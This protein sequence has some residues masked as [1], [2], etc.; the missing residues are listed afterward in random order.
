MNQDGR[1]TEQAH[2]DTAWSLPV[3]MRLPSALIVD[4]ANVFSLLRRHV[5]PG[6]RYIEV[7]CAPG[8]LLAW[9][10][11]RLKAAADGV[12]YSETGIKNCRMLFE[13]LRLDVGLFQDDFFNN[14][15]DASSYDVV[16]SFG[17]IEHFD[18]PSL[19]VAKHIELLKPGG[20]ALIT[21]PN[22]RSLYGRLQRWCDAPNLALRNLEIMTPP[23][24]TALVDNRPDLTV[25]AYP[26]GSMSL[27][28]VSL[29]KRWPRP[30][31][32][33]AQWA[34]NALGLV[35]FFDIPALA[36][37]LVLEVRLAAAR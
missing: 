8:K 27:W 14:R 11:G 25:K 28:L 23:A 12:D 34:V 20:V 15:L 21:V 19:A 35:Q 31:A 5:K 7:G 18:D 16:T 37:M 3:R 9:V 24:L 6:D 29:D 4:T 26:H 22:Y 10:A 2:W 32:R 13:A 1:K 30:L 36:P 17:F 33:L